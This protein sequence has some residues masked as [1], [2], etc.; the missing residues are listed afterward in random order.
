MTITNA[1]QGP[2]LTNANLPP[3]VRTENPATSHQA[4]EAITVSGKR[5]TDCEEVLKA[6]IKKPG[7]IA[8]EI[9]PVAEI[10][11]H[12]V[13]KR[14]ADLNRLGLAYPDGAR[15]SE[16]SNRNQSQWFPA[17]CQGQLMEG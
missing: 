1:V 8:D 12:E 4:A 5:G 13:M 15:R 17:E 10:M 3:I 2:T 9:A 11:R 7:S 14:T 16:Q 6:I